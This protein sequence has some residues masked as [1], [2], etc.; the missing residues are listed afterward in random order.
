MIRC[1]NKTR[2]GSELQ[3]LDLGAGTGIMTRLLVDQGVFSQVTAL[4]PVEGM[5]KMLERDLP[6]VKTLAGDSRNIPLPSGSQDAIVMAQCFHWFDDLSS[7]NEM[8]RVLKPEGYL[9]FLWN[10]E[11]RD[12]APWI[13]QLANLWA[14]YEK[15]IPLH[16][17]HHWQ[18]IFRTQEAKAL[19]HLPL[20]HQSYTSDKL[21]THDQLWTRIMSK[22]YVAI[23][24]QPQKETLRQDFNRI[25]QDQKD[26]FLFLDNT[27]LYWCQKQ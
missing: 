15:A 19:Y 21:T 1:L 26:P 27:D 3:V 10:T 22:S 24:D 11:A 2:K 6:Q 25:L 17:N 4:E 13:A 9:F 8:H 18:K 20:H 14:D 23:L 7:L 5:R 16:H 12:R